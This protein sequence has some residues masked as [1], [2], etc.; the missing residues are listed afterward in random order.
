MGTHQVDRPTVGVARHSPRRHTED[1]SV[2][3]KRRV[4]IVATLGPA[5][6]SPDRLADLL[7]AGA[8]MVRI[9]AA[10]GSAETRAQLI[11]DVRAAADEVGKKVPILFDLRGLKIRTGPLVTDERSDGNGRKP[12]K[13]EGS[14]RERASDEDADWFAPPKGVPFARGSEV[15][16]YPEPV[17]A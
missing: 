14:D 12:A 3:S 4:K 15:E 6:A 16:I 11:A 5:V 9:N 17:P 8:D 7:R 2:N 13:G 10:H 1:R